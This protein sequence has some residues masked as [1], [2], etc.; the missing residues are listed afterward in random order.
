M[1]IR[2][3]VR[4]GYGL[5]GIARSVITQANALAAAGHDVEVVSLRRNIDRPHFRPAPGVRMFPLIDD[6]GR[7]DLPPERH[8]PLDAEVSPLM[9]PEHKAHVPYFTALDEREV[10][11]YVRDLRDGVL[12]TTQQPLSFFAARYGSPHVVRVAQEH[13]YHDFYGTDVR[14]LMG[15]HF[16]ALDAVGVL[17][18]TD[19]AAYRRAFPDGRGGPVI[20]HIPNALH[21]GLF[22]PAPLDRKVVSAVGRLHPHKGF[23]LLIEAFEQ[24][25][26]VHPDWQLRIYGSGPEKARLRALIEA[27]HLYNHVLLMGPA[28]D[29]DAEYPKS[30]IFV[31]SSRKEPFGLV[32]LEAMAHGLPRIGFDGALGC[33]DLIEDG[34]TGL[35]VPH[36]DTAALARAVIRLIESPR[37]RAA[38]GAAGH[39]RARDYLPEV[40]AGRWLELFTELCERRGIPPG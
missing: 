28:D 36:E 21:R 24:V 27:R 30:S 37:L 19:L 31:L 33:V 6:R 20:R 7:A 18:T 39:R 9:G 13:M 15:I 5:N 1:R 8:D 10:S 25:V 35:L 17:T 40:I 38:L 4:F 26:R 22:P 32:L 3:L 2:Y 11:R 23:D 12:V 14:R 34:R 29:V 16:P